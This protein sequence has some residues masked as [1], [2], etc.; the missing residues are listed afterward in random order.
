[1]QFYISILL[2][3]GFTGF[4]FA[5]NRHSLEV[6]GDYGEMIL[7]SQDIRPIGP[8]SPY[9]ISLG[10]SYWL[11][12]E[13]NWKYCHCFPR[14]GLNLNYHNFDNPSILGYGFPVYG[15][16]EPWYK[17]T[18]RLFYTLRGGAGYAWLSNPYDENSN[19]LNLSY[20]LHFTPFIMVGTGLGVKMTEHW[21]LGVQLRY[22]HSSNGGQREPNKGLNYPTVHLGLSYSWKDISFQTRE[23]VPLSE[24][25]FMRY[26]NLSAFIA[27]KS[28]DNTHISY[29]VPGAA[30]TYTHQVW[31]TSAIGG[32]FEWIN[33]LANRKRIEREGLALDHNQA[34]LLAGHTF[35][36]GNFTFSQMI[37]IYLYH[38]YDITPD[39]YQRYEIMWFPWPN[40]GVG[41]S[42]KAHGHIAEFLDFRLSYR[43]GFS[44]G[45][46]E[47]R[48]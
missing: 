27:G 19:P 24:L 48:N 26:I 29:A 20:S 31:R 17:L 28:I 30:I 38:P 18:P 25:T 43:F 13:K 44:E 12:K 2:I 36:L 46:Q 21:R 10:Y 3:V 42:L 7:H 15:F 4:T 6:G 37:G 14:V 45:R 32:G 39:W 35:L 1:M 9:G 40:I 8:S 5:Q 41:T 22:N 33:N 16:L 47:A 34:G 11:L 23:D